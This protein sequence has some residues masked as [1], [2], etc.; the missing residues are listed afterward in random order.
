MIEETKTAETKDDA[1]FYMTDVEIDQKHIR[2]CG[3]RALKYPPRDFA[4]TEFCGHGDS[5]SEESKQNPQGD[6]R[7]FLAPHSQGDHEFS[8]ECRTN[9]QRPL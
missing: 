1:P 3:G 8:S 6:H 7:C 4:C 5:P 9:T 2:L